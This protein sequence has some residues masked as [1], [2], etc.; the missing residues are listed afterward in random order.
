MYG[1]RRGL[2]RFLWGHLK[3][4]CHLEDLGIDE[5]IILKLIMKTWDREAR[6]GLGQV[7]RA[8]ES[9]NERG[10]ARWQELVKGIRTGGRVW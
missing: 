5:R 3:E 10:K 9:S 1:G 4:R 6:T 7:A 2:Y 8:G